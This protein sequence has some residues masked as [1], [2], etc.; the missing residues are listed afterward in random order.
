MVDNLATEV[1]VGDWGGM[2]RPTTH[3]QGTTEAPSKHFKDVAG[4]SQSSQVSAQVT[5]VFKLM[6]FV[7][8]PSPRF[9]QNKASE[10]VPTVFLNVTQ[11]KKR[12]REKCQTV[13]YV[14][15]TTSVTC[16]W[17]QDNGG[18]MVPKTRKKMRISHPPPPPRVWQSG[19][20]CVEDLQLLQNI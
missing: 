1:A 2:F 3:C 12:R 10:Q 15:L 5:Y 14:K 13:T 20:V 8:S 4:P 9:Q 16:T 6:V 18:K 17:L 19:V 11:M 7:L